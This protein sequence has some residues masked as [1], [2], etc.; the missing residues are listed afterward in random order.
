MRPCFR[1]LMESRSVTEMERPARQEE[2]ESQNLVSEPGGDPSVSL[3]NPQDIPPAIGQIIELVVAQ[4]RPQPNPLHQKLTS[5]HIDKALEFAERKD[6]RS[7]RYAT[8][9]RRQTLAYVGV[10]AAV[11]CF[12]TVYL[13][14]ADRQLYLEII[15]TLALLGGGFGAGFGVKVYLDRSTS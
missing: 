15:K 12:L 7:F 5:E 1:L 8:A 13:V 14:S 4:L 6:E 11:F 9:T 10:V 3:E 2:K